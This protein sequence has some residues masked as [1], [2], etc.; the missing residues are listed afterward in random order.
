MSTQPHFDL[1]KRQFPQDYRN[2]IIPRVIDAIAK[3]DSC[4]IVGMSGVGKSNFFRYLQSSATTQ[5]YLPDQGRTFAFVWADTNGLAGQISAFHLYEL[6][7]YNLLKWVEARDDLKTIAVAIQSLHERAV[8]SKDRVLAQR[9][10]ETALRQLF[11][12]VDDLHVVYLFDEFEPI[13][14][15]LDFTFFRNMRWLR[16]EFKYRVSYVMAAHRSPTSINEQIFDQGE[17]LYELFAPNIMGLKPYNQA[18]TTFI[19][20]ELMGR[21]DI[22][23]SE[24][25]QEVIATLSG[26]HAG[27]AAAIFKTLAHGS[28]PRSIDWQIK[29]LLHFDSIAGECR[30]IWNSLEDKEQD[31][32]HA[33]VNNGFQLDSGFDLDS[34]LAKG[35]VTIHAG[36]NVMLFSSVFQTFLMDVFSQ[37]GKSGS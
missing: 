2:E 32:L 13:I 19:I 30:K 34:L 26:G 8:L 6:M 17:P 36:K 9:H 11:K 4:Y 3:G 27:L 29:Q 21:Y 20:A 25:H 1:T 7:L 15:S 37:N 24:K 22:E 5:R 16:D 23:L 14:K 12:M 10:F 35:A 31:T 33:L 28:L 18:D